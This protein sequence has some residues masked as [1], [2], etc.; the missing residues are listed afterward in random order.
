MRGGAICKKGGGG[1]RPT[2]APLLRAL[3]INLATDLSYKFGYKSCRLAQAL[4]QMRA[5]NLRHK[6]TFCPLDSPPALAGLILASMLQKLVIKAITLYGTIAR[7]FDL[8]YHLLF[9][10]AIFAFGPAC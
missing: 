2:Y 4:A 6:L 3:V 10:D 8:G 9:G 7:V 1:R 5:T